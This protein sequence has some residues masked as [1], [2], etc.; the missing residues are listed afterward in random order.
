MS[1]IRN[2]LHNPRPGIS[3]SPEFAPAF[4]GEAEIS[5]AYDR[6][7][8]KC[9]KTNGH[10]SAVRAI[11]LPAGDWVYSAYMGQYSGSDTCATFDNRGVY[12]VANNSFLAH[13]P[14]DGIEKRY[15][16]QFHLDSPIAVLLR[17]TGPT[18]V[19]QSIDYCHLLL[20][21]KQDYDRMRAL[22]ASD[23]KPLNL[24]WFDGDTYPAT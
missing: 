3:D 8:V 24:A 9:T 17:L 21:S 14:F 11:T 16:V 2:L 19:G 23:G 15:T 20:S 13:A 7:G 18:T 4:A 6:L 10:A 12:V 5:Y 22:T 1:E